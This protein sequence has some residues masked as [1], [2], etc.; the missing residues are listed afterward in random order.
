MSL[1]KLVEMLV[2]MGGTKGG[3]YWE[4]PFIERAVARG[5]PRSCF[6]NPRID[7]WTETAMKMEDLAKRYCTHLMFYLANPKKEG[8][9][10]SYFSIDEAEIALATTPE[11]TVVVFDT[12]ESTGYP[13]EQIEILT[14]MYRKWYPK[15]NIF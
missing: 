1:L 9:P 5:I 2:F 10:Q 8:F 4:N 3:N 7:P 6:V 12:S 14:T 13:K 15:A 11:R